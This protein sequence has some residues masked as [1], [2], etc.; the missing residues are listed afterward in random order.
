MGMTDEE[1]A[2]AKATLDA[3]AEI[4]AEPDS[5]ASAEASAAPKPITYASDFVDRCKWLMVFLLVVTGLQ[6][7]MIVLMEEGNEQHFF[8]R[9]VVLLLCYFAAIFLAPDRKKVSE[10]QAEHSFLRRHKWLAFGLTYSIAGLAAAGVQAAMIPFLDADNSQH[11]SYKFAVLFSSLMAGLWLAPKPPEQATMIRGFAVSVAHMVAF[12]AIVIAA[13]LGV[14]RTEA[15]LIQQELDQIAAVEAQQEAD[16]QAQRHKIQA[17]LAAEE[18]Q[19]V[20]D[21]QAERA[22]A[23]AAVTNS[24]AAFQLPFSPSQCD[25][26]TLPTNFSDISY[27]HKIKALYQERTQALQQCLQQEMNKNFDSYSELLLGDVGGGIKWDEPAQPTKTWR[28]VPPLMKIS[29]PTDM[30]DEACRS[31]LRALKTQVGETAQAQADAFDTEWKRYMRVVVEPAI[32][33]GDEMDWELGRE[34]REKEAAE[35]AYLEASRRGLRNADGGF[36]DMMK[37]ISRAANDMA[38]RTETPS[39]RY[40]RQQNEYY[41]QQGAKKYWDS[42]SAAITLHSET[43]PSAP[44]QKPGRDCV[45]QMGFRP[46]NADKPIWGAGLKKMP[47]CKGLPAKPPKQP[48]CPSGIPNNHCAEEDWG[49]KHCRVTACEGKCSCAMQK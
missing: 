27:R 10:E 13:G 5:R 39:N 33:E 23:Q 16:Q 17:Q 18:A 7:T 40:Q 47:M 44:A 31:R 29:Y 22:A 4:P 15:G 37:G 20:A 28:E 1:I 35:Q 25:W 38:R 14:W 43:S 8:I 26:G 21:W 36:S 45:P 49:I 41:Q 9:M 12:S 42:K 11:F 48:L 30:C 34:Q 3:K 46:K 24:V 2:A 19:A 6:A 32:R